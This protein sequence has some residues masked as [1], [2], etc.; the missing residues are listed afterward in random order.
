MVEKKW[1]V[2]RTR[3]RFEKKVSHWLTQLGVENYLPT[4][5]KLRKWHDRKKL[6]DDVLF[7]GYVFVF[8]ADNKRHEVFQIPGILRYLFVHK[9]IA[10]ISEQEIARIKLFCTLADVKINKKPEK[11]DR[12]EVICGAL[13]GLQGN[14]VSAPGGHRLQIHIPALAC[15]ASISVD[16]KDV[17]IVDKNRVIM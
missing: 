6:I 9:K 14:I 8:I 1:F 13:I 10:I 12:V 11:G 7:K 16:I 15:F 4:H 17:C 3:S 2:L 5:K